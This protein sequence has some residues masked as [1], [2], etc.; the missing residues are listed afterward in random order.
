MPKRRKFES[1]VQEFIKNNPVI[2]PTAMIDLI[3]VDSDGDVKTTDIILLLDEF[4]IAE[5]LEYFLSLITN[6]PY[7]QIFAYSNNKTLKKSVIKIHNKVN[8][9]MKNEVLYMVPDVSEIAPDGNC[10]YA[11]VI[12]A[13]NKEMGVSDMNVLSLRDRVATQ[14]MMRLE[15]YVHLLETQLI[16]LVAEEF[17]VGENQDFINIMNELRSQSEDNVLSYIRD[18]NVVVRYVEMIRQNGVWG[19]EVEINIIAEIL[20]VQ[21]NIF[22]VAEQNEIIVNENPDLEQITISFAN[23]HY[24]V[25]RGFYL[26]WD[27]RSSDDVNVT[28]DDAEAEA[29]SVAGESYQFSV[30]EFKNHSSETM[31]SCSTSTQEQRL[32]FSGELPDSNILNS[33]KL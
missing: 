15:E 17:N 26:V 2:N 22:R 11:S 3:E 29:K 27:E 18:N 6:V 14:I 12:E 4:L 23:N 33:F 10:V 31:F 5:Q 24:N 21:I 13:Y 1:L 25:V 7:H 30:E 20:N 9:L 8:E 19:G 28:I 32:P 16:D